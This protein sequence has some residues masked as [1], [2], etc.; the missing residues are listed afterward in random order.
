MGPGQAATLLFAVA[1]LCA[2]AAADVARRWRRPGAP[3]LVVL[4]LAVGWWN[5][6]YAAEVVAV[7]EASKLA[8]AKLQ[9][10]GIVAVPVAA[11]AFALSQSGR[12]G[13]V[14]ASRLVV[15][16]VVPAAMLLAAWTND[17]HGLV[18]PGARVVQHGRLSLLELGHGPAFYVLWVYSYLL[19]FTAAVLMVASRLHLDR[20]YRHQSRLILLGLAAP[21]LGNAAYVLGFVPGPPLDYTTVGFAATGLAFAAGNARF[22]LLDVVP[23]ARTLLLEH[24]QEGV[25]VLDTDGRI[26]DCNPAAAPVLRGTVGEAI[27]R[28]A[29]EVLIGWD[30]LSA[31]IGAELGAG[32][33]AV[34]VTAQHEAGTAPPQLWVGDGEQRRCFEVRLTAVAVAGGL[35]GVLVLLHDVTARERLQAHLIHRAST[36]PLTGLGN[37]AL[38][39]DGLQVARQR[40]SRDGDLVGVLLLDLDGLKA[41]ND[42]AGHA[43]GD[44]LLIAVARRIEACVRP[45][46]TVAR[47]GGDEFAVVLLGLASPAEAQALAARIVECVERPV[48]LGDRV[49]APEIS[50]GVHVIDG[51]DG[52]DPLASADAAMYA[53]KRARREARRMA[54]TALIG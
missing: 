11:L 22:R 15:L 9:Y 6:G 54:A 20:Y 52:A 44:A 7:G 41:V 38:L 45:G 42:A 5:A 8:W 35:A 34:P 16:S 29:A 32:I 49:L 17:L 46:D 18:W 31:Q 26:V 39:G 51:A 47:L 23:V 33:E 43:V 53:A 13:A 14:R 10:V 28:P 19:L 4:L 3:A 12:S 30:G 1:V 50:V 24:L 2:A 21:W 36:D 40:A 48:V 25:L 37:R 27:G